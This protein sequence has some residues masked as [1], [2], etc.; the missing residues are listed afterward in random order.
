MALKKKQ[1]ETIPVVELVP[2]TELA[3]ALGVS[4]VAGLVAD[5][6]VIENWRGDRCV[7]STIAA[8]V[9]AERR[10]ADETRRRLDAERA[11][12]AAEHADRRNDVYRQAYDEARRAAV[13]RAYTA[14]EGS[15]MDEASKAI[16]VR[17]PSIHRAACAAANEAVAAFDRAAR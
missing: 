8:Q 12:L 11:E 3:G 14:L 9:V 1:S 7:P 17:S 16:M 6:D 5:D 13:E 2:L 15:F 4:S 10:A